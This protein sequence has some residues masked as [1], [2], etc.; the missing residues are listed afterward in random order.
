MAQYKPPPPLN[1]S[2]PNWPK[3]KS[4]YET[5]RLLTK[6]GEES[7]DI[8]VASIKYCMGPDAEDVMKTFDLSKADSVKY[9]VVL[10]KFD[11]YF[12]PRKNVLRLRRIFYKRVQRSQEDTEAYLRALFVAA[13]DC[14]FTDKDEHIRDQ[15]VAGISNDDLA[16]KI[17]MLYFTKKGNLPLSD[18]VEYSRTYNDVHE[19][20][21]LEKEQ[22]K[23]VEEVKTKT[24]KFSKHA[25]GRANQ[26]NFRA[27]KVCE[28]C[29]REH[30]PRRCPAWGRKCAKC[31]KKNHF[32]VKCPK[33]GSNVD[34]VSQEFSDFNIGAGVEEYADNYGGSYGDMDEIFLGEC[35]RVGAVSRKD[36]GPWRVPIGIGSKEFIFKVDSGADASL[37]NYE[38]YQS[39]K[40]LD[41]ELTLEKAETELNSPAGLIRIIG[42]F[43]KTVRYKGITM[44]EEL[45]VKDKRRKTDKK[46][47]NLLS[48]PA[49]VY[50]GLI[51]RKSVV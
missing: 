14:G 23:M 28:Y 29:D 44:S 9:D 50:L 42:K 16:E 11:S 7:G 24:G 30:E 39:L 46:T 35:S 25:W 32:A 3:W 48:R 47:D 17:E 26:R 31:G 40:E 36:S 27:N 33:K 38:V 43:T 18:V 20:R 10:N 51:D 34:D 21:K 49:S 15:F 4:Q 22:T 13:E 5:F 8:Q 19:G 6:L 45:Y 12:T 37:I 1:F 41:E 2:E